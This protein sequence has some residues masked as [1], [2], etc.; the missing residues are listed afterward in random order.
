MSYLE[1]KIFFGERGGKGG[2]E[3][4]ERRKEGGKEREGMR[5]G[6]KERPRE[7]EENTSL[8]LRFDFQS[9]LFLLP[10]TPPL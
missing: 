4:R 10:N 6:G 8:D 5:E 3:K 2:R 1:K 9:F 7:E